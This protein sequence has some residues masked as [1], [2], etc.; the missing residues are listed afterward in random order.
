MEIPLRL[1]EEAGLRFP[2]VATFIPVVRA[3]I[4]CVDAPAGLSGL[5]LRVIMDG[6][7]IGLAHH[8]ASDARLVGRDDRAITCVSQQLQRLTGAGPPLPFAPAPHVLCL[9]RLAI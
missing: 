5:P 8:A 7:E 6:F 9:G 3:V 4:D 2:A 1:I